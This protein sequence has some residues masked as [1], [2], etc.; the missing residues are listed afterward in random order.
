VPNIR[1]TGRIGYRDAGTLNERYY[2]YINVY[3]DNRILARYVARYYVCFTR[4][5]KDHPC[6]HICDMGGRG[7]KTG[8]RGG[9]VGGEIKQRRLER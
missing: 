8:P 7:K 6:V 3:A 4:M 2:S 5:H 1:N 9:G